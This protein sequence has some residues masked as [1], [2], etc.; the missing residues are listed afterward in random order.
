MI[1]LSK[2]VPLSDHNL[3]LMQYQ[4]PGDNQGHLKGIMRLED[5]ERTAWLLASGPPWGGGGVVTTEVFGKHLGFLLDT[6]EKGKKAM[7]DTLDACDTTTKEM[8]I[9][10]TVISANLPSPES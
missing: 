8:S 7:Q 6:M 4:Q 5:R 1:L 9:N 10:Y 3:N 2:N